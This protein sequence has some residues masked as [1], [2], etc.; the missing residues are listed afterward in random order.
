[1]A[2]AALEVNYGHIGRQSAALNFPHITKARGA[3]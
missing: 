3:Q 2:Q 1:M